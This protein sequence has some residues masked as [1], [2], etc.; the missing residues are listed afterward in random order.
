[1]MYVK[2]NPI[3]LDF[4][5][6]RLQNKLYKELQYQGLE[7]YGRVYI[8]DREGEKVP[9]YYHENNEYREVLQDDRANGLFFFFEDGITKKSSSRLTTPMSLVFLLDL[10]KLYP[11]SKERK[12]EE[13]RTKIYSIIEQQKYFYI[14]EII[15]GNEVLK[16]FKTNL[17]E[18]HPYLFLRFNGE[19][20]YQGI[21]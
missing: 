13:V 14:N 4:L 21:Y 9:E 17:K 15:K 11:D 18:M 8:N 19:M 20:K 10:E 12:D 3:G 2:D 5:V 7:A 16:D 6:Q 1:M